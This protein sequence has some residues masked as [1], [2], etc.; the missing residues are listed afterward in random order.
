MYKIEKM[1]KYG[2]IYLAVV[3]ATTIIGLLT[4]NSNIL[5]IVFRAIILLIAGYFALYKEYNVIKE[6]NKKRFNLFR[7][8]VFL[9]LLF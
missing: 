3:F 8:F 5:Y 1:K 4:E 7:L 2:M 6:I 9:L